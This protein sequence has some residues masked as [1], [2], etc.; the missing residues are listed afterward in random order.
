MTTQKTR[1]TVEEIQQAIEDQHDGGFTSSPRLDDLL[2]ALADHGYEI[3][4]TDGVERQEPEAF[5]HL[6]WGGANIDT[7]N[8]DDVAEWAW[9]NGWD[10]G[11]NACL[12][13]LKA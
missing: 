6:D 10:H 1:P 9:L 13:K 2:E 11:W 3:V 12:D 8:N 4:K 7:S 5:S